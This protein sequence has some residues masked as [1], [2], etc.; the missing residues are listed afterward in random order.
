MNILFNNIDCTDF[1]LSKN[2]YAKY[3]DGTVGTDLNTTETRF[4]SKNMTVTP[5][6]KYDNIVGYIKMPK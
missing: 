6:S 5:K 3:R 2:G 4:F 1:F